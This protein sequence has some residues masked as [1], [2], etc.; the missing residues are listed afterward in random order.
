MDIHVGARLRGKTIR[1]V[2]RLANGWLLLKTDNGKSP[3]DFRV[4]L[5][6]QTHPRVRS[7]TPKHAHFVIDFYG[8]LCNDP[9]KAARLFEA[10]SRVWAGETVEANIQ[11]LE[12]ETE[13]LTG[14]PVEYILAAMDWILS[15]EDINFTTRPD[16]KQAELETTLREAGVE[17]IPSRRGSE[18]A[19]AL[20]CNVRLGMHPVEAFLRAQL[21]V[22]PVK[23]A[24]GAV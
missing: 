23:R 15:Q 6:T 19:M 5:I 21:D 22:I 16:A 8:K 2:K 13:G 1:E 7:V 18:L 3:S 14:Y 11:R 12:V 10:I 20:L 4:K 24:R 9:E 17:P